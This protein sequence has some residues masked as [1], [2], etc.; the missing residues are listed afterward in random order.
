VIARLKTDGSWD[1]S[2]NTDPADDG[3]PYV[4]SM[5]LQ[6]DGN[7][8]IGGTFTMVN[9]VMRP[10]IARLFGAPSGNRFYRLFKP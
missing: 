7:I 9:G 10:N 1:D 3:D 4:Y 6:P 2:F 5:L 8:L